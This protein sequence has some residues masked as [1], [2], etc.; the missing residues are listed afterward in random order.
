MESVLLDTDVFSFLHR[1]DTRAALY[2]PDIVGK[3]VCLSF[4]SVGELRFGALLANWGHPR[5]GRLEDAIS[6]AVVLHGDDLVTL[7]WARIKASRQR[8]GL[9]IASEDCWI[10]ATAVRRG[11]PLL[12]HNAADFQ[13]IEGLTVVT[14]P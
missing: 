5:R 1:A 6:H 9:A 2:E 3:V 7:H 11:I 14:H 13:H 8:L 10:A 12:T 4:A